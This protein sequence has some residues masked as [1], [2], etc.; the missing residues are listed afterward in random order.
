MNS[1]LEVLISASFLEKALL[2]VVG[3]VLTGLILPVVKSRMDK[4]HFKQQKIFEADLAR[5]AEIV[6]ARAQFLRDLVD[7]VW[8]FQLLALQISYDA[9]TKEKLEAAFENYDEQSWLHLK[10]IRAIIG[11]ARWFTSD[12]AYAALTE[13]VDG[14]LLAS[15]DTEVMRLRKDKKA[16]WLGFNKRLYGQSRDKTDSLLVLLAKDFDLAPSS[17][18]GNIL[19]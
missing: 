14:W 13:F 16:D 10:R 2:L 1:F 6:K 18:K 19:E 5:Q 12:Y 4:T 8:Q 17:V 3:G 15:I 11:G 9:P 7:P